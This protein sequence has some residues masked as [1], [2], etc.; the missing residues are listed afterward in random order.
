MVAFY[1]GNAEC[2]RSQQVWI[3]YNDENNKS[4]EP[5]KLENLT[6]NPVFLTHNNTTKII[7]SKFEQL[8][9]KRVEWW[10]HC[11]LWVRNVDIQNGAIRVGN[12]TPLSTKKGPLETGFLPRCNP[13]KTIDGY[14]LPLYRERGPYDF[15]GAIFHSTDAVTWTL[16]G[17]IGEDK[18]T[19]CI[20]PTLWSRDGEIHALLR[21][22]SRDG[23]R[24][25]LYS[26]SKDNGKTW[27]KLTDSVFSNANNSILAIDHKDQVLIVWNNDPIGRNNIT[28][29]TLEGKTVTKL[30]YYGSYPAACIDNGKLHITW[31][32][33]A[34]RLKF[35]YAKSVIKHVEY[36]LNAIDYYTS[37]NLSLI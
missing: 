27:E 12:P 9:P 30:D 13:I 24:Q 18:S 28:L 37:P 36:N 32:A 10:Q 26:K 14:L 8:V 25:A 29:G 6:G 22:F 34:N 19:P 4:Y 2:D 5:V 33:Q 15:Y 7:Y 1:S 31:T 3:F 23:R 21:N 35:P 11:S 16:R 20:Q 17:T